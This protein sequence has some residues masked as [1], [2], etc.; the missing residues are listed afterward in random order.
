MAARVHQ[1]L[2]EAYGAPAWRP[3]LPPVD[4]LV[5]TILSQNTNDNNRDMAFDNMKEAFPSWEEVRDVPV[6]ELEDSIKIAGLSRQKAT[7][8]Q[9]ALS[10]ITEERGKI[11][12][13]FLRKKSNQDAMSWLMD[14]KGVGPKTAA[15][16][17]L[18]SL[19]KPAFPVDTHVHRVTGRLG[20]RPA[21]MNPAKA[22]IY[23]AE[24]FLP[25][26]YYPV[27]LNLIRLGREV[28]K[29]RQPLC[30][31]CPLKQ[32]CSYFDQTNDENE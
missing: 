8:I 3:H 12:L 27:H 2:M 11:E 7:A 28:C 18:F 31:G 30:A 25:E 32:I 26:T 14:L 4:E 20:L 29:A 9:N 24:Q 1:L 15:I 23:L 17:L 6:N 5:S 16:V 10:K 19:E 13:E 22:H 21:D